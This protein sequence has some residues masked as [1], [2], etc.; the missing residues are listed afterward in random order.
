MPNVTS[1]YITKNVVQANAVNLDPSSLSVTVNF[2]TSSGSYGW[3]DT[4]NNGNRWPYSTTT[5]N[6][7]TYN[8]TNTVS[9]TVTYQWVPEWY[10]S[11]PITLTST[12]IMPVSY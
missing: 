2:N 3:D 10:L 12:A 5:I 1:D 4:A 9:V 6:S 8:E 11:G 7:Q